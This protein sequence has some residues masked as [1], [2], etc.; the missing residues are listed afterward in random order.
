MFSID[1]N[2]MGCFGVNITE[3]NATVM[4]YPPITSQLTSQ[5]S[6]NYSNV[7]NIS[8]ISTNSNDSINS[9]FSTN[10][11]DSASF[12]SSTNSSVDPTYEVNPEE[13]YYLVLNYT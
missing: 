3:G 2:T 13:Q 8:N 11:N 5:S 12:N 4:S 1:L 9:N 6:S 7:S 10:S